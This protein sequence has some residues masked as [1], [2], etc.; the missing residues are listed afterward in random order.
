MAAFHGTSIQM[1]AYLNPK[2]LPQFWELFGPVFQK[3]TAE[4]HCTFFEVYQSPEDP[5][6]IS[7]V[8]NWS[9]PKEWLLKNQINKSYYAEYRE[10]MTVKFLKP[11]EIKV[12]EKVGPAFTF[13]K[14][15][16]GGLRE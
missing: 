11:L 7:W 5:G 6:T 1:T 10:I 3:V 9:Q 12:R 15:E 14:R 2:D 4:P 8:E 16:N 13:F